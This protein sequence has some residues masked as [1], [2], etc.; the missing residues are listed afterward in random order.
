MF[1]ICVCV[2]ILRVVIQGGWIQVDLVVGE[3]G[4]GPADCPLQH[5]HALQLVLVLQ[6]RHINGRIA[7]LLHDLLF[8]Q[9]PPHL[10][11]RP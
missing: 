2:C 1:D 3:V 7:G 9:L 5:A 10:P 11:P 6:G 4:Q 8:A